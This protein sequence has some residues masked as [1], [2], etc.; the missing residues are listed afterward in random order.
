MGLT[1]SRLKKYG[2]AEVLQPENGDYESVVLNGKQKW[3]ILA[4]VLWWIGK[5][6]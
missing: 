3:K 4:R 2:P 1:V 5:A 6:P